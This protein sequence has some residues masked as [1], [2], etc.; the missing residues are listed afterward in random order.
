EFDILEEMAESVK[1]PQVRRRGS[2]AKSKTATRSKATARATKRS[3]TAGAPLP[4][5]LAPQLATLVSAPPPRGEWLYELKLDGYRL[6]ARIDGDDVRCFTRNGNDWSAR[7]PRVVAALKSL[8]L[9]PCWLDG[10]LVALDQGGVPDFQRLQNA[11]EHHEAAEL[12]YLVFDLLFVDG[13]DLR[14]Q[15]QRER[16]ARLSALLADV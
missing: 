5:L 13:E 7:V 12:R 6:L 8:Q 15:S 10:E 2:A 4:P 14:D 9:P 16:T 3:K 11:F 1:R